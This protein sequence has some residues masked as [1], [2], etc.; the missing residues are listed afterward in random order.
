MNRTITDRNRKIKQQY[1]TIGA[2][3]TSR[4]HSPNDSQEHLNEL[5]HLSNK[6]AN[7]RSTYQRFRSRSEME[8]DLDKQKKN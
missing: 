8:P 4:K 2:P 6:I 5:V 3:L 7:M 1:D